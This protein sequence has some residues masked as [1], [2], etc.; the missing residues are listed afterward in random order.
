MFCTG[1]IFYHPYR[2]KRCSIVPR[3]R[4]EDVKNCGL[5]LEAGPV[6]LAMRTVEPEEQERYVA[7]MKNDGKRTEETC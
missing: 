3:A 4:V 7:W 6:E 5:R 2:E 1:C